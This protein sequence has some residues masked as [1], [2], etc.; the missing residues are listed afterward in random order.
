MSIVE[1]YRLVSLVPCEELLP[2]PTTHLV[3]TIIR[4]FGHWA[5][6]IEVFVGIKDVGLPRFAG[7]QTESLGQFTQF[8][9]EKG[10]AVKNTRC[11]IFI[12]MIFRP[13]VISSVFHFSIIALFKIKCMSNALAYARS[14]QF[15]WPRS[16]AH[17]D[18]LA[19]SPTGSSQNEGLLF[20]YRSQS[21]SHS[22]S[23][24]LAQ[25]CFTQTRLGT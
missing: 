17:R 21:T 5:Y 3:H 6:I 15:Y 2:L 25:N 23:S 4:F 11:S 1:W 22:T 16:G 20:P 8:T 13:F 18:R 10:H 14:P 12:L 19:R 9:R 7:L 24:Q